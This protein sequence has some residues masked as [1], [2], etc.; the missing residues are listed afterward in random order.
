[1]V[2]CTYSM[3][4]S[5]L[6]IGHQNKHIGI[7]A[8]CINPQINVRADVDSRTTNT[9]KEQRWHQHFGREKIVKDS[10]QEVIGET[11]CPL[12]LI[13]LRTEA[14]IGIFDH[15]RSLGYELVPRIVQKMCG[16]SELWLI[17]TGAVCI[18]WFPKFNGSVRVSRLEAGLA[19]FMCTHH[20]VLA[21]FVFR[22]SSLSLLCSCA[23]RC[24]CLSLYIINYL[25]LCLPRHCTLGSSSFLL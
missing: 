7:F 11:F 14:S 23:H 24:G 20:V 10:R 13:S 3:H 21:S 15:D 12:G 6:G 17:R 1:M 2:I 5:G 4:Q 16:G 25:H 8:M 18:T 19:V 9:R 22:L